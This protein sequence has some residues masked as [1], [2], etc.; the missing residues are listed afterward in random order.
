MYDHIIPPFTRSLTALKAILAKA[1]AHCEAKKIDPAA[2]TTARLFPDMLPFVRQITIASDSAKGAAA[3][4]AGVEIPSFPDTETSFPEL[5][6]RVQKTI[7]FLATFTPDSFRDAA[8]RTITLKVGGKDVSMP[9]AVF[10]GSRA[11][12]NFH[13]HMTTAYDI[14][15]HSGVE[16]GK[17]DYLGV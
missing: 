12:P 17:S 1:E 16:L 5:Q 14:L 10:L 8:G 15:R 9:A 11:I 2:L 6:A 13:F 3:R 7:D 4:L